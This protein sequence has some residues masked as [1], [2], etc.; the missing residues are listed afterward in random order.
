MGICLSVGIIV[1]G[2]I[3]N[4]S[5]SV[6]STMANNQ[7]KFTTI[8]N[9]IEKAYVDEVDIN[10]IT[11]QS[12]PKILSNLDPHTTYIPARDMQGVEES[13]R[14]S[15]SGI[16]VQFSIQDDTVRV[17]EV[18]SG[19]PSS[20][21]GI[22][23]G[24]RIISVND[25]S[26]TNINITNNMVLRLLRGD[27]NTKVLVGIKRRGHAEELK[28]DITRGDIPMYSIDAS[29]M[30]DNETG[31]I[32]ISRFSETTY[33]E[34]MEGMRKITK[35]GASKV[36]IDLRRNSGGLLMS[37]LRMLDEFLEKGELMLYTEGLNQPRRTFNA[38]G[39]NAW[40]NMKVYVLID[41]Y[42][43]S[44]S[45]IFA[46]AIQ[47][48]DRGIVIG[49]RSFGKG[50]VQ[51]QIPLTDGSALRLT[52][53]RF[54]TPS[55]RCIQSPYEDEENYRNQLFEHFYGAE[56]FVADSIHVIDSLQYTTKGGRIVYGGGGIIPDIFVPIDTT[57]IS[58]Y[59][60]QI[61]RKELIPSFA[62][63]YADEHRNKLTALGNAKE[64]ELFF[65]RNNIFNEFIRYASEKDVPRNEAGLKESGFLIQ[66]LLKAHIVRNI[67][68]ESE[69]YP[70][71]ERIDNTLQKAIEI[72]RQNLLVEN[73]V[74]E[75]NF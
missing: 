7:N 49:R 11:E 38:S 17:V 48:N 58:E 3:S 27:K 56:R 73:L 44:A 40:K 30:I 35:Q 33:D 75:Q 52:V 21:V 62:Y 42:S 60:T 64:I 71:I 2:L 36:I 34:F 31:L 65:D 12:I 14:G 28:F 72:S 69:Y 19:G 74:K 70:I 54:Y 32:K 51:E 13:M 67:F 57:G 37:V 6:F 66:T 43:A 9:L 20:K 8:L 59:Y 15:F 24:D 68:G 4:K 26:I 55:G 53:A 29:Y 1:G 45:E 39:R 25:S 16:G 22:L 63:N 41:E 46:G 61:Y 10:A 50:L 5:R 23:P 18:I 47:D